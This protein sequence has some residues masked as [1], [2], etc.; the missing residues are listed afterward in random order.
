MVGSLLGEKHKED[1]FIYHCDDFFF[2]ATGCEG[3]SDDITQC[4]METQEYLVKLSVS[5]TIK[6]TDAIQVKF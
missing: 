6:V 1:L 5:K 3:R 2:V 4:K